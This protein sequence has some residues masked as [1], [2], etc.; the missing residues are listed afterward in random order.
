[1]VKDF[2]PLNL[3][4]FEIASDSMTAANCSIARNPGRRLLPLGV[5]IREAPEPR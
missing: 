5:T 2:V 4:Y 1:M 3:R